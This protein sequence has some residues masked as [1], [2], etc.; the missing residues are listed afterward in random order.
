[1]KFINL[2]LIATLGITFI[3]AKEKVDCDD[4]KNTPRYVG[5]VYGWR[6]NGVR[7]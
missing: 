5:G 1:M 3:Y 2:F 7:C 4:P 6:Q